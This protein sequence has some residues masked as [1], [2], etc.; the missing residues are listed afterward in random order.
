M[1]AMV[2]SDYAA[3]VTR[4]PVAQWRETLAVLATYTGAE[5]WA[6]LCD[7][8][9][10]RLAHAGMHHAASLCYV[11]A[12]N[13]DQAVAYWAKA[14]SA[15]A[16]ANGSVCAA[17]DA[18]AA[19]VAAMQA[20]IEKS[21]VMGLATNSKAASGALSD[22]VT[23]YAGL[24]VAQGRMATALQYLQLVPGEAA[25]SVAVLKDRIYRWAALA[26]CMLLKWEAVCGIY[27]QQEAHTNS[28]LSCCMHTP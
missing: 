25:S 24:L 23:R 21:I 26:R 3:L 19:E 17:A 28:R 16:A 9:A 12:G 6:G 5:Q 14:V 2:D 7:A 13:V 8:L 11:C 4:R 22:L 27:Q 18:G 15:A 10:S 20:V 1:N